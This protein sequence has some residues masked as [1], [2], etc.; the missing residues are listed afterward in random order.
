MKSI[1]SYKYLTGGGFIIPKQ[2]KSHPYHA[3]MIILKAW[4]NICLEN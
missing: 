1:K 4:T 2:I 3:Q